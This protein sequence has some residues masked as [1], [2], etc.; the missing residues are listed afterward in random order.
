MVGDKKAQGLVPEEIDLVELLGRLLDYK[1]FIIALTCAA[2]FLGAA[3]SFFSTRIYQSNALLQ[4]EAKSGVLPGISEINDILG[5]KDTVADR[6]IQIIN[7]RLVLGGVV[8]QL[9]MDVSV[10]PSQSLIKRLINPSAQGDDPIYFAG[11]RDNKQTLQIERFDVPPALIN[12]QLTLDVGKEG[13]FT[14]YSS[15][16]EVL[17]HSKVGDLFH[18]EQGVLLRVSDLKAEQ[19]QQFLIT[20][21]SRQQTVESLRLKLGSSEQG[22]NTNILKLTLTDSMP[23]RA[24]LVLDAIS[25][26]YLLQNIERSSAQA[27][28]SLDFINDQLPD[29]RLQLDEAEDKL[30]AYRLES[31]S[32]D[33]SLKTRTL[34]EQL[35]G[36]DEKINSLKLKESEVASQFTPN[37]PTYRSLLRQRQSLEQDKADL[38]ARI[39]ELPKT[40]QEILRLMRDV[41]TNRA[42]Y[43]MLLVKSQELKIAKASTVG[44][45]RIID[46]AV[47]EQSPIKPKVPLILVLSVMLGLML[48]VGLVLVKL[49]LRRGLES[50]EQIEQSGIPVYASLPIS[51][52]QQKQDE[53]LRKQPKKYKK[54]AKAKRVLLAE[55]DP[56]DLTVEALRSLRTSLHFAMLD[57]GN[58]LMITGAGVGVGKTFVVANFAVVL[59]RSGLRVLLVDSDLRRGRVH[60]MFGLINDQGGLSDYLAKSCDKHD[61]IVPSGFDNLDLILRGKVPPNPSELLMQPSLKELIESASAQYD[62]VLIDTP[63]ILAVTDAAI[64]GQLVNVSLLVVRYQVNTLKE[65]KVALQRFENSNVNIKGCIFNGMVRQSNN[66]YH[67]R[68]DYKNESN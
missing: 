5:G 54:G 50:P 49:A 26:N 20:K 11:W 21:K 52:R 32:V 44:N 19:G 40:Q 8:E 16:G 9:M 59:A 61:A 12:Q 1:W 62:L 24:V 3:Y 68:Y 63:P 56:T 6:E 42:T 22:K 15:E 18:G 55:E 65:L 66:S 45:V 10:S 43:E 53:L 60:D 25:Q 28:K 39:S 57:A 37:H 33:V 58:V 30:N 17:G 34:M 47:V 31:E 23:L 64:V 13:S 46:S 27:E 35:V 48:S 2:L 29:I 14:L 36:T 38:E 4:I 41:E 67:Y 51:V 7:S